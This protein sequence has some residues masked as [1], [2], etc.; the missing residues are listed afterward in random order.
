MKNVVDELDQ[1]FYASCTMHFLDIHVGLAAPRAAPSLQKRGPRPHPIGRRGRLPNQSAAPRRVSWTTVSHCRNML[2]A[3]GL[4]TIIPRMARVKM[5]KLVLAVV[6]GR[7]RGVR[8]MVRLGGMAMALADTGNGKRTQVATRTIVEE[9]MIGKVTP[10]SPGPSSSES[11]AGSLGVSRGS[12]ARGLTARAD[13]L[14]RRMIPDMT[15]R[16]T[17]GADTT[18]QDEDCV[19]YSTADGGEGK[20]VNSGIVNMDR[21]ANIDGDVTSPNP[22]YMIEA[23]PWATVPLVRGPR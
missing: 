20:E 3:L 6:V 8:A 13:D 15:V 11:S 18:Y 1:G 9:E 4:P 16:V 14:R 10:R 22:A 2:D 23:M 21:H 19:D 5:S 12:A 17:E 7:A